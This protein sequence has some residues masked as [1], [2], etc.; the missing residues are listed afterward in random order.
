MKRIWLV[1]LV[2][3]AALLLTSVPVMGAAPDDNQGKGP[4]DKIV[5]VHYP[6][7]NP[8]NHGG[9]GATILSGVLFPDY[10]YQ[11]IHW[12][13]SRVNYYVNA[14]SNSYENGIVDSFTTW[15]A[16]STGISFHYAGK[17][18]SQGDVSD[19]KNVVSWG[20]VPY[21][22]AIAVTYIWYSRASK[23][24]DEV[25]TVMNSTFPW[26]YED[27]GA[28]PSLSGPATASASRYAD[29]VG[30]TPDPDSYDVRDIM[31]HEAGHWILLNDLYNAKDSLLT[32]YGYGSKGE[33][34]KDTLGYGDELGI[35]KAYGP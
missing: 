23:L 18:S 14:P 4:L 9:G 27:T 25:D 28:P 5:F 20:S 22:N 33:I 34:S 15:N 8:A 11:G 29:P 13:N 31:T 12:A 19:G 17:T 3:I 32:M 16:A 6:K 26:A 21:A 24:I 10:K 30:Y 2:L 1:S 7:H 35:E